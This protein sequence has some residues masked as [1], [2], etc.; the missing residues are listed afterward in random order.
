MSGITT[1]SPMYITQ[2]QRRASRRRAKTVRGRKAYEQQRTAKN[3]TANVVDSAVR[4]NRHTMNGPPPHRALG[5]VAAWRNSAPKRPAWTGRSA[6]CAPGTA[7]TCRTTSLRDD[8]A[9]QRAPKRVE[10]RGEPGVAGMRCSAF[11]AR[12]RARNG[13]QKAA[14]VT[15][16][17]VQDD[18]VQP[19][20]PRPAGT[21]TT[22]G[23]SQHDASASGGA[24]YPGRY[25]AAHTTGVRTA[26]SML[27]A[28]RLPDRDRRPDSGPRPAQQR[29]HR[30]R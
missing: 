5:R 24:E 27:R 26:A 3:T 20:A 28:T 11:P 6:T 23:A 30:A 1:R 22:T 29:E 15:E 21:A 10:Q 18:N 2:S 14:R 16:R 17:H 9:P 8:P 7:R 25:R 19:R 4:A 13:A 12:N